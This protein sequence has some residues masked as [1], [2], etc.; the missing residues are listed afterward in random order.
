M[1]SMIKSSK[2]DTA[3]TVGK[4]QQQQQLAKKGKENSEPV[5]NSTNSVS[6]NED[7]MD[8]ET[9]RSVG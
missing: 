4:K 1:A 5:A 7:Q 3:E 6:N 8:E 2:Y 9:L